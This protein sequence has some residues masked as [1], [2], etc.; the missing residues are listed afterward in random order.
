MRVNGQLHATVALSPEK[1]P[2]TGGPQNWPGRCG[3]EKDLLALLEIEP[4]PSSP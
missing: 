3:E 4:R 2:P 1:E